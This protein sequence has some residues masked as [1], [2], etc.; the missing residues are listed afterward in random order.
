MISVRINLA[1]QEPR[2]WPSSL[3][4]VREVSGSDSERSNAYQVT[5]STIYLQVLAGVVGNAATVLGISGVAEEYNALYLIANRSG[6][7]GNSPRNHSSA[8]AVEMLVKY[9]KAAGHERERMYL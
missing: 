7:L 9:L 8:L 1:N 4:R 3:V 2:R 6:E 5:G